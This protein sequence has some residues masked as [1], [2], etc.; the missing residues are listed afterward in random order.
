MWW[1]W[2]HGKY[3]CLLTLARLNVF[4]IPAKIPSCNYIFPYYDIT[5]VEN[6]RVCSK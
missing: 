1:A 2:E 3:L 5:E 4:Y 6:T